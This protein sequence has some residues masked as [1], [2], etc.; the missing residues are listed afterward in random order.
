MGG[1]EGGLAYL[2]SINDEFFF[3]KKTGSLSDFERPA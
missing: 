1:P 3:H 2:V